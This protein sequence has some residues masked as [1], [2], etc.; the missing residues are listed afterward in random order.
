MGT[1][2]IGFVLEQALGHETVAQNLRALVPANLEVTP[3]WFPVAFDAPPRWPAVT[4][5]STNWSIRSSYI[6]WTALRRAGAPDAFDAL[7]FHT[8]T[9]ALF[10]TRYLRR[11][12][13]ILSL[14]ATPRNFDALGVAYRHARDREL[15][16]RA[17]DLWTR[18]VYQAASHVVT[19]TDWA[20]ESVI[21]DYHVPSW[22]VTTIPP[23]TNLDFWTTHEKSSET[24]R[25]VRLLFV[26]GDFQ[27]KG[28]DL[29]L[30]VFSHDFADTCEL[31]I[32]T[33]A[34]ISSLP[35]GVRVHCGLAPNSLPLQ[36]LFASADIFVLPTR[37]D[38]FSH[39]L[40]EAMAARLPVIT[41][42]VGALGELVQP[43]E[44]GFLI[45][46]DDGR[47]LATAL[48]RQVADP[49]LRRRLGDSGR[50]LAEQYFDAKANT[51]R[52][53]DIIEEA[54]DRRRPFCRSWTADVRI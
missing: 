16:G 20:R 33:Y 47:A 42:A 39:V 17:K 2:R 13:S 27:R 22:L 43:G 46:P 28:G 11:T 44:N 45:E 14:D 10:S 23:G 3:T 40:V 41:T 36:H 53:L 50:R 9:T 19:F 18:R 25:R 49:D 24:R 51:R 30:D 32:V 12:A 15:I 8:Q 54:V 38:C 1:Y 29:L 35:P 31:D 6:A 34:S 48:A 21:R 26:G 4:L 52:L 7:Y 37:A 5:L